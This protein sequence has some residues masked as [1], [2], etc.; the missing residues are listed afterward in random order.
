MDAAASVRWVVEGD[1]LRLTLPNDREA[2]GAARQAVFDFLAAHDTSEQTRF[3][4]EL[5]LEETLMNVIWHAFDDDA[6]HDID[7]RVQIQPDAIAMHFEDGGKAF[8]PLQAAAP[9]LPTSIDEAVPGGLGL[10]L[11]RKFSR[12]IA[13]ERR[14][15]RNHLSITVAR[16]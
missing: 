4:V 8:D 2:F 9:T 3:A 1:G 15:E 16:T 14:G 10:M 6:R 7:L 5:V 11:V 13:Y 12:S